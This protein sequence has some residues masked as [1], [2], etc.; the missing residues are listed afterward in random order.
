[1]A[2]YENKSVRFQCEEGWTCIHFRV[3]YTVVHALGDVV[4]FGTD[5]GQ[6]ALKLEEIETISKYSS[7]I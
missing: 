1:M 6:Q 3:V 2:C 4:K 7:L 5:N